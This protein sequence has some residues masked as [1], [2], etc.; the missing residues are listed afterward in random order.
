MEKRGN[1]FL[2]ISSF[3]DYKYTFP[4]LAEIKEVKNR[5]RIPQF[6]T[7]SDIRKKGIFWIILDNQSYSIFRKI[8]S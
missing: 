1:L 3:I 6:G 5:K 2:F 8:D 7:T 4:P